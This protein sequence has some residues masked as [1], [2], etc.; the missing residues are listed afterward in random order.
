MEFANLGEKM[1]EAG[2]EKRRMT[3]LFGNEQIRSWM[4]YMEPGDGTDMHYHMS[5]ETFLV[6]EGKAAVKGLGRDERIIEK[7]QVV[8]LGSKDYYQITNVGTGPLIL[9]GN[10]S[11]G[12]G[13]PHVTAGKEKD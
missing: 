1:S 12:F 6:L 8:F 9:F 11:E 3:R 7:N 4:L 13:G 2:K 5:P 10:R